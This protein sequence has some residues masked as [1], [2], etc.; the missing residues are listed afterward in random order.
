MSDMCSRILEIM[1]DN[2]W[3][4]LDEMVVKTGGKPP[5]VAARM[6]ALRTPGKGGHVIERRMH[7]DAYQYRIS[8]PCVSVADTTTPTPKR[9]RKVV[10]ASD[11][12]TIGQIIR[13]RRAQ[14]FMT[15]AQLAEKVGVKAL[16]VYGWETQNY[17][18]RGGKL[19]MV[20][21]ALGLSEEQL[22]AGKRKER[23]N[24][25]RKPKAT[26]NR[27]K[28]NIVALAEAIAQALLKAQGK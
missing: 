13:G 20:A 22:L 1:S 7:N 28:I 10:T 4:T 23:K 12:L 11:G 8:R 9:T 15:Q 19:A 6:R 24:P 25:V 2:Q 14:L 16:A 18:P 5:S 17:F 3:H 27:N 26:P 21:E